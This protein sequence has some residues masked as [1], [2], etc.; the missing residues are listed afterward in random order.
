MRM[1]F[2]G[3]LFL[4][5]GTMGED[6]ITSTETQAVADALATALLRTAA[7]RGDSR[8]ATEAE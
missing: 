5:P 2:Y 4:T 3:G 8:L 7:E 1:A 6:T